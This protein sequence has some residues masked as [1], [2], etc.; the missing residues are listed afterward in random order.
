MSQM[1]LVGMGRRRLHTSYD[2]RKALV[3]A[4]ELDLGFFCT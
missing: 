2:G 4:R 3:G 1:R